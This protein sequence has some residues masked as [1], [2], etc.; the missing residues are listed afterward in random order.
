MLS[1]REEDAALSFWEPDESGKKRD[2]LVTRYLPEIGWHLVVE[3][4]TRIMV[5]ELNGQVLTS[6]VIICAIISVILL[7]ISFV[8]RGFNR[9]IVVLT[10]SIEQERRSLFQTA[11]EQLF[12]NIYE[13]DITHNRPAN[14]A[15][16][17][18]FESLGIPPGTPFDRALGIIAQRQIKEEFRAGYLD[19]FDPAHVLRAYERGEESLKYE[20][21]ISQDGEHY[22]WMRITARLVYW[23]TD[24][25]LHMLVYR[26]NIDAE[27][28]QEQRMQRLAQTDEMT[29]FLTKTATQRRIGELLQAGTEGHF[30]YFIF[31]IDN[32]KQANDR[33]G[34]AFGD[35]VIREFTGVMRAHFRRDDVLGRI[36]GDEFVAFLPVPDR[37]WAEQRAKIL[38][39]ELSRE[40]TWEGMTWN[41]SA[42]IGVSLAPEHGKDPETLYERADAALYETKKRGKKGYT[43][44]SGE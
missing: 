30:A 11:T 2:Y 9:R 26:Q 10:Q 37:A 27:K 15:T 4:D 36:G 12:E 43:V 40:H 22:Y 13:L 35:S 39:R 31:D 14:R 1:W 28:W 8:I 3:R 24:D 34:H 42:S 41:M 7:I 18:Y 5:E 25:S 16:E 17:E 33:F 23:E 32:F 19:T 29:G 44:F 20:F 38:S 21:M 6:V